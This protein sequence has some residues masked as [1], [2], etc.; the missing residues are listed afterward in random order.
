MDSFGTALYYYKGT[1]PP[2]SD[3]LTMYGEMDEPMMGIYG[4]TVKYRT[5]YEGKNKRVFEMY[6]LAA[7]DNYKAME[8]IYTRK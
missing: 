1:R 2:M 5:T 3:V 7:G 6:D 8:I 4:R